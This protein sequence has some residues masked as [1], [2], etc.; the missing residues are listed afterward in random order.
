M[1]KNIGKVH[2]SSEIQSFKVSGFA[3]IEFLIELDPQFNL[4]RYT[5]IMHTVYFSAALQ[6]IR[7]ETALLESRTN[8][9]KLPENPERISLKA[10][11]QM[12]LGSIPS[13]QHF[14]VS[15]VAVEL[16]D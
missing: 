1:P 6:S 14:F 8:R 12:L 13:Q 15:C 4:F 10:Q 7:G 16:V 3:L 11:I 9:R 2:R 5:Q